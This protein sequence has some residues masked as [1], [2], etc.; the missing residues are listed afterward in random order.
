MCRPRY[1]P[2]RSETVKALASKESEKLKSD[3]DHQERA[4]KELEES[5]ISQD[6]E[7]EAGDMVE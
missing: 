6:I 1:A 3:N 7:M 2:Q 5:A 4:P